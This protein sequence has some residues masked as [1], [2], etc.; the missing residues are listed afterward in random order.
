MIERTHRRSRSSRCSATSTRCCARSSP[1]ELNYTLN[2]LADRA[3]GRGEQLGE[4]LGTLDDYLKRS[5][6]SSRPRRRTSAARP[7]RPTPTP[8]CS[9]AR[10]DPAQH[11]DH[12]RHAR[13][14]EEKLKALFNDVDGVLRHHR[15]LPHAQRRQ[16][17]PARPA[18]RSRQLAL[19]AKYSPE[20][21]CLLERHRRSRQSS[22]P[23][24]PR[25]H[26]PHRPRDAARP[27]AR[28]QHRG[29]PD[30]RRPT[31]G[32]T[33]E[34][35]P[36]R[37]SQPGEPAPSTS[38]TSTTASTSRPARA[39][40]GTGR[41]RP[42]APPTR[43]RRQAAPSEALVDALLAPGARRTADDVPDLG[44]ARRS[45]RARERR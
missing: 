33:A 26:P 36:T 44:A 3:R 14:Q 7:G 39:P 13:D 28:L 29:R 38:P 12:R 1:R 19:L 37:R 24:V 4:T 9:R 41:A 27:A 35:C 34:A 25:L 17:R 45:D 11:D 31:T 30:L 23:G 32:R 43:L 5:T 42:R 18:R 6:R 20:Y 10:G 16:H 21:P 40:A 2:A 8:T 15:G 22:R